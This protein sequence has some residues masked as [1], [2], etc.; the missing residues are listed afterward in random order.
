MALG[1]GATL[2]VLPRESDRVALICERSE[3]KRLRGCPVD[4]LACLNLL[5]PGV[6]KTPHG[7][8]DAEPL[9]HRADLLA[10]RPQLC[11]LHRRRA[12]AVILT[13]A[14][15]RGQSGPLSIKPIGLVWLIGL[16]G[17]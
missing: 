1:K 13:V 15:C 12:T 16:A 11:D 5:T 17:F 14:V 7:G 9:R 6:G 8:M 10:N 2:T 3:C 4:T